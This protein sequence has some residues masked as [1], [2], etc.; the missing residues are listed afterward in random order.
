MPGIPHPRQNSTRSPAGSRILSAMKMR[1]L[2][3]LLVVWVLLVTG[4]ANLVALGMFGSVDMHK[5][6]SGGLATAWILGYLLQFGFF[7]WIMKVVENQDVLWRTLV[8]WFSGSLLPWALDWTPLSSPLF[9]VWYAVAIAIAC[10]IA[11]A[12]RST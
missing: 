1:R 2:Y 6:V 5:S 3:T 7:M 8:W 9:P 4:P 11:L 12:A 10:W